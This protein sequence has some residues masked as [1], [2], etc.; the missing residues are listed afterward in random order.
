MVNVWQIASGERGRYYDDIFLAYDVMFLGPGR[1]GEFDR[2]LY[3]SWAEDGRITS[4]SASQVARFAQ[5]VQPGDIV[6]LRK[7]YQV[8]SIGA[9][10]GHTYHHNDSLDD[11][12]GWD[13]QHCRSVSWHRELEP[14]V[15]KLQATRA[16]FDGRK[17]IPTFTAVNDP[18]V[19]EPIKHLFSGISPKPVVAGPQAPKSLRPEELG[20]KLFARGLPNRSVDEV[21]AALQRQQRLLTWYRDQSDI[22]RPTEHEVVAH[23]VLPLLLALG[24]SEQLL[25]IE[26]NRID[27]AG[28]AGTPTTAERCV[29]VCEAKQMGQGMLDVWEQAFDYVQKNQLSSCRKIV[30]TDGARFYLYE[31]PEKGQWPERP[32]GYLNA[33]NIREDHVAPRGTSAVDTIVAL[34]PMNLMG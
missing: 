29:L 32:T 23:M 12:Y 6:L 27:L 18:A 5:A 4:A 22:G 26:W 20:Q 30:T 3:Q 16:L 15:A 17:Q 1:P 33:M 19:I 9:A 25:A 10:A 31:R 8:L 2:S 14:E 11:V 13:L 28:F 21:L 34:T 7:G 24:W